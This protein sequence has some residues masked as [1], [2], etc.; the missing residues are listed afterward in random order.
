MVSV[1]RLGN[2]YR[3][4]P[5]AESGAYE[6]VYEQKGGTSRRDVF[7]HCVDARGQRRSVESDPSTLIQNLL[8]KG[9]VE[10]IKPF[11]SSSGKSSVQAGARP[12]S[13]CIDPATHRVLRTKP[14]SS[15]C[16]D[17][18]GG[19][20]ELFA[21]GAMTRSQIIDASMAYGIARSTAAIANQ[22]IRKL[23]Y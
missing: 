17:S 7:T 22:L 5:H 15:R 6:M 16:A 23:R 19:D 9:V 2:D 18:A 11:G 20:F 14:L 10:L 13:I 1:V 12:G 4:S 3:L 8:K 21:V